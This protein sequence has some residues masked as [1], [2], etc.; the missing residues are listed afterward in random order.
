MHTIMVLLG[1]MVLLALTVLLARLVE[2]PFRSLVPW[3]LA[4]W[5]VCAAV[6]MWIGIQSAGYSFAEELPI[7]LLI[8]GL[9]AVAALIV[10]R[11]KT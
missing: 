4:V 3:F 7:F 9:P 10:A 1:G 2:R 8:F 6:N 5:F 11:L